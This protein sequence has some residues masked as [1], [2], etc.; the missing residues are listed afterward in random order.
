MNDETVQCV[1]INFFNI[2]EFNAVSDRII[3]RI[4]KRFHQRIME[5]PRVLCQKCF[6]AM[7]QILYVPE[8]DSVFCMRCFERWPHKSRFPYLSMDLAIRLEGRG[9]WF[10]YEELEFYGLVHE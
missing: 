9:G 4:R 2:Q 1:R 3:A 10:L 6:K 5:E 8:A 7:V